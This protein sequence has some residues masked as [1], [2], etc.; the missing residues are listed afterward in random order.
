MLAVVKRFIAIL[1]FA[2]YMSGV[3]NICMS[4][5]YCGNKLH[6]VAF[7]IQDKDPCCGKIKRGCCKNRV[8]KAQIDVSQLFIKHLFTYKSPCH[9]ANAIPVPYLHCIAA[10]YHL[11]R[12]DAVFPHPPP[13]FTN[14]RI[15][16]LNNVFLI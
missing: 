7:K 13:T 5:H 15:H 2:C 6:S 4:F 11:Y 12:K 16:L 1:V 14:L 9:N 8:V 10:N 3:F